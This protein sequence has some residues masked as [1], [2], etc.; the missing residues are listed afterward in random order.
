M[1]GFNPLDLIMS[2]VTGSGPALG[3][4]GL[5]ALSGIGGLSG[6]G[7]F[8]NAA[9]NLL[10]PAGVTGASAG[11]GWNPATASAALKAWSGPGGNPSVTPGALGSLLGDKGAVGSIGKLLGGFGGLGG[12]QQQPPP[13]ELPA[14]VAVTFPQISDAG[15]PTLSPMAYNSGLGRWAQDNPWLA[16]VG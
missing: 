4:Q 5:S 11:G 3:T 10:N 7:G 15:N 2:F 14:P 6:G 13:P 8:V 9:H 12:G 1:S 16:R